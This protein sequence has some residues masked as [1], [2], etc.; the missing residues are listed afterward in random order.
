MPNV[1]GLRLI[2]VGHGSLISALPIENFI[3]RDLAGS[4]LAEAKRYHTAALPPF[5]LAEGVQGI[6]DAPALADTYRGYDWVVP[7]RGGSL[8]PWTTSGF[9][10][11]VTRVR[12]NFEAGSE[13][14]DLL[15]PV[16]EVQAADAS[17]RVAGR[18]L[19]LIGGQ[20]AALL[21]AF[22][23]LAAASLRRDVEASWRRLTWLG[24]R[25]SQLLTVTAAEW[26]FVALAGTVLGWALGAGAA[27]LLA[28]HAN[29]PAAPV[30]RGR[31]D[32]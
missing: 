9:A 17:S 29:A 25:R 18:R 26:G 10:R 21:L 7:L 28:E 30:P 16:E 24:A 12:S 4:I 6:A 11:A 8:H 5:L 14:F 20:T 31:A 27:A 2:V 23:L 19:L 15:A 13:F 1:P 3:S 32:G 22:T